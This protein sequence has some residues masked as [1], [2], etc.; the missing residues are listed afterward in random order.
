MDRFEDV[1][2]LP[3]EDADD[4]KRFTFL[5]DAEWPTI[6]GKNLASSTVQKIRT[7]LTIFAEWRN[8]R[9]SRNGVSADCMVPEKDLVD[10]TEEELCKWLPFFL[11][12]IRKRDGGEYRAKTIFEFLLCIQSAIEVKRNVHHQF[13]KEGKFLTIR[14]ALDNV[15]KALQQRGLGKCKNA[16][17]LK[18]F[19]L[20]V[21]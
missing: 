20:T 9:N 14:N 19:L 15:M 5:D 7:V 1:D 17:S 3:E 2:I 12:E 13:L 4:L 21:A 6:I 10:F 11:H 18:L 8:A 16:T